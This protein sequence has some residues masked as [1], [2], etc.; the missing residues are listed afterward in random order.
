MLAECLE[1]FDVSLLLSLSLLFVIAFSCFLREC[2]FYRTEVKFVMVTILRRLV[3]E[4]V[5]LT[6]N[7]HP[8]RMAWRSVG[9]DNADLINQLEDVGVIKT[10]LVKELMT[11][12]DRKHYCT[13][14]PYVD[15]PQSIGNGVTISAPHMHAYA[16]ENLVEK[17]KY[18]GRALDVGSG[19]GYLTA[20]LARA[21]RKAIGP[22]ASNEKMVVGIEHQATL[23]ELAIRNINA[24]DPNFIKNGELV[25]VEGDGRNGY[26]EFAPYDI[27]HVGAA[28]PKT[29][30]IL[31][32]QLKNGGRLICPVGPQFG[33]QY[34]EMYD[35]DERGEVSRTK[36]MS[37]VY[38]PLTDLN[39]TAR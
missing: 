19:S 9:S 4:V 28:A 29:P 1:Q 32:S 34:L 12:T 22:K 11:E 23:V 6:K 27:I 20:C 2:V 15:A 25:I 30:D 37:V 16:L 24:D 8:L 35:K 5:Y 39:G 26:E 10:R 33:A 14:T 18:G 36:L 38:V 31:L 7:F 17:F 13:R 3:Q 21:N